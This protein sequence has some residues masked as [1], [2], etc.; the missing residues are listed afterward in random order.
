M[1][2]EAEAGIGGDGQIWFPCALKG[3]ITVLVGDA[4]AGTQTNA[5]QLD[6]CFT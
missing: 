5:G 6:C 4:S 3:G 2:V 1:Q